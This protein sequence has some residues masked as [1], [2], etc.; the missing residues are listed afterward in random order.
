MYIFGD[1][2]GKNTFGVKIEKENSGADLNCGGFAPGIFE[3]MQE[4]QACK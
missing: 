2:H 3:K 1:L 4:I